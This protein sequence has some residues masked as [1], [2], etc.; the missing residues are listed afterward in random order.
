MFRLSRLFSSLSYVMV[1]ISF[2]GCSTFH[3]QFGKKMLKATATDPVVEMLCFW[4]PGDGEDPDGVPCKGFTGQ[5][6]FLNHAS[7]PVVVDGDVRIY[8]FDDQGT[9]EEQSQT[10]APV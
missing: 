10:I 3:S 9:P 8:L 5:I 7:K 2:A 4:E 6:L 1:F